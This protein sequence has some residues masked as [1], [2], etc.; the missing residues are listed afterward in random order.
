MAKQL[1]DAHGFRL[2][3][4]SPFLLKVAADRGLKGDRAGLQDLGDSLDRDT[5]FR[6]VIDGVTAPALLQ[7]PEVDDWLLDCVRKARQ[8]EHFRARFANAVFHVHLTAPDVVLAVRYETRLAQV[9]N[10]IA[11]PSFSSAI[12]HPN[13]VAARELS[14]VADVVIDLSGRSPDCAAL[15]ISQRSKGGD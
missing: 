14:S 13:E 9:D 11:L 15:E 3:R 1:V 5:D 8:V 4:T 2:L 10:S 7:A 12:A 6:W